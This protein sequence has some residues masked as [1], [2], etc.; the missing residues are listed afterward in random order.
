MARALTVEYDCGTVQTRAIPERLAK[1][2]FGRVIDDL[3]PAMDKKHFDSCKVCGTPK[4]KEFADFIRDDEI[5]EA[6][7]E[8]S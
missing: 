6:I 2:T 3:M 1:A 8:D 5:D 4:V 7:G